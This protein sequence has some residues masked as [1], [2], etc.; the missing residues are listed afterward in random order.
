MGSALTFSAK[1]VI[2]EGKKGNPGHQFREHTSTTSQH[3]HQEEESKGKIGQIIV[4]EAKGSCVQWP[5][6]LEEV[7]SSQ[8]VELCLRLSR[9]SCGA[10]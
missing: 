3:S 7:F 4:T 2:G 8:K 9:P 1:C 10:S 6:G 5:G